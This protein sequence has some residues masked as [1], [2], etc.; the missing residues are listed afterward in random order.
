MDKNNNIDKNMFLA[1]V[2]KIIDEYKV[3]I[4]KGEREGI[5]VGQKFLIYELEREEIKDPD[6]DEPLGHLEI[7]K[8]I[9][10]VS[11]VQDRLA[12]IISDVKEPAETRIIKRKPMSLFSVISGEEEVIT[13]PAGLAPFYE[14]KIGD[15]AK[16]I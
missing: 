6:T 14:P 7:V 15:K 5:K 11:H 13:S 16:P 3:V 10:R 1:T 4:N 9:G 2:V 8:G 12:T